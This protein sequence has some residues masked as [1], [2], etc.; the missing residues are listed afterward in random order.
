MA[1]SEVW[2]REGMWGVTKRGVGRDQSLTWIAR[3]RMSTASFSSSL[4]IASRICCLYRSMYT[5]VEPPPGTIPSS[6]AAF[7]ELSA[8]SY[9]Q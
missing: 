7:T 2:E 1:G 6:I 9:L 3:K 4:S 8:S 5:R